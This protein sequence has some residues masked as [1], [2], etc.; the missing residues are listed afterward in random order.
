M[1]TRIFG[2]LPWTALTRTLLLRQQIVRASIGAVLWA[3][4]VASLVAVLAIFLGPNADF[5]GIARLAVA[6]DCSPPP[7]GVLHIKVGA[8]QLTLEQLGE[9]HRFNLSDTRGLRGLLTSRK[10]ADDPPVVI[11]VDDGVRYD[12]VVRVLDLLASLGL[13][14]HELAGVCGGPAPL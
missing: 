4:A 14:V 7:I 12:A 9:F 5:G 1:A 11:D 13:R 8:T 10:Q 6:W 3:A 2:G